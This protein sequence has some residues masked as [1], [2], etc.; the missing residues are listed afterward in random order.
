MADIARTPWTE[1]LTTRERIDVLVTGKKYDVRRWWKSG[2]WRWIAHRLPRRLAL[3]VYIRVMAEA[4]AATNKSPDEITYE[5][6][7]KIWEG[8]RH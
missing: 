5:E 2:L 3:F 8:K 4:W 7:Y 1:P 6:A